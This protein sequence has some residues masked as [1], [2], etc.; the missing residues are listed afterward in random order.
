MATIRYTLRQESLYSTY[1]VFLEQIIATRASP[2]SDRY[3]ENRISGLV[4]FVSVNLQLAK[5]PRQKLRAN[6]LCPMIR[7]WRL[8]AFCWVTPDLVATR[9]ISREFAA[10]PP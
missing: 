3:L 7:D 4:K 1:V 9:P 6:V 8:C 2:G 10:Q 5:D